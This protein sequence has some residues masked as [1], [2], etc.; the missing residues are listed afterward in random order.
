[1]LHSIVP[2]CA[3]ADPPLPQSRHAISS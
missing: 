2:R 3:S 1:V